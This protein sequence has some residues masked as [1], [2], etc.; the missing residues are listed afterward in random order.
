MSAFWP[1]K[2]FPADNVFCAAEAR[3]AVRG[4]K[5]APAHGGQNLPITTRANYHFSLV[6][7]VKH[8]TTPSAIP[9]KPE[10]KPGACGILKP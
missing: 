2:G 4:L 6:Q 10:C 1:P 7:L 9:N 5:E 8:A 3:G